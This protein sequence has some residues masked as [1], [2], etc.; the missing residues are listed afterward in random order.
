MYSNV[1]LNISLRLP[2]AI[3]TLGHSLDHF[4]FHHS[5][6]ETGTTV[7]ILS[8]H[9][10]PL[11]QTPSQKSRYS[12]AYLPHRNNANYKL[13][14]LPAHLDPVS[15]WTQA[16]LSRYL[17]HYSDTLSHSSSRRHESC[18]RHTDYTTKS[19]WR[20]IPVQSLVVKQPKTLGMHLRMT[21]RD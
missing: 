2:R 7:W 17:E 18:I 11:L 19:D 12:Y 16:V 6:L 5:I 4:T 10:H 9:S 21:W 20:S 8:I 14:S 13:C 15:T 1:T 3:I